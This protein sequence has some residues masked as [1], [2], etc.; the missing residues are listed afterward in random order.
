MPSLAEL[1]RDFAAAVFCPAEDGTALR[2]H[3]AG[4]NERVAA[5]I[6]AYRRSVLLNLASAVEATYPLLRQIVGE[7]FLAEAARRYALAYPS[8]SGDLNAYGGDFDTFLATY[9]PAAE[10]PWLPAVAE[11]E[12]RVQQVY[13][14]PDPQPVDLTRLAQTPPEG[15]DALHFR[16]DPGHSILPSRWP[17][18]RIWAV[19]QP[20][21]GGEMAVDFS[22]AETVLIHRR[23]YVTAVE[24]LAPGEAAWLQALGEGVPLAEAVTTAVMADAAFD[25]LAAL[26]RHVGNGLLRSVWLKE[27]HDEHP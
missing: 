1:Q 8:H 11:L 17:L 15:W 5:G 18:A 24:P 21:Y 2:R 3:C 27:N 23:G 26:E 25:L 20:D 4:A 9:P 6:A 19:N 16:L 22:Q 14:A 7:A 10:L 12:W 13:A